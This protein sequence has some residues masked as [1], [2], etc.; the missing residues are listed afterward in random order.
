MALLVAALGVLC[1]WPFEVADAKLMVSGAAK[2]AAE[3]LGDRMS[4][5]WRAFLA[6]VGLWDHPSGRWTQ[7]FIQK[8]ANLRFEVHLSSEEVEL[9]AL[10]L[11][12]TRTEFRD[13]WGEFCVVGFGALHW[14]PIGPEN[15]EILARRFTEGLPNTDEGP[16]S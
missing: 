9:A 7:E 13:N 11:R 8:R 5:E 6:R 16:A 14:Y 1:H 2:R 4:A 15:L 10:A 3:S 12:A